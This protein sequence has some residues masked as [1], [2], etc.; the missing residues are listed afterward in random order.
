MSVSA[1]NLGKPGVRAQR[2]MGS[3]M[4][5]AGQTRQQPGGTARAVLL[6]RQVAGHP[7]GAASGAADG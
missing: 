3:S 6:N 2:A 7:A 4:A 5:M 1:L